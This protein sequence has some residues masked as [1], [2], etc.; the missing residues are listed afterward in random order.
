MI[1]L[2]GKKI[3]MTQ[4]FDDEGKQVPLTLIE[5]S[6][7]YVTGLRTA[8][9]HGYS[10]VQLGFDSKVK[11]KNLNK[12]VVGSF[13]KNG[14]PLLRFLREIRT[15]TLEGLEVAMKLGVEQFQEGEFVD[16][17]GVSIGKGF[18]GV[19]KRHHFKGGTGGRGTK[20]GREPGGIGSRAGGN[21]CRKKVAKGKALPGHMGQ[22][23]V[24]VQ[25][26]KVVKV[27]SEHGVIA[28]RGAVPGADGSYLEIRSALK[29]RTG[30]RKWRVPAKDVVQ[31]TRESSPVVSL[32]NESDSIGKKQ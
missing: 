12:S 6:P 17:G 5:A 15:E 21:G 9:K 2:L 23:I 22:D 3:G 1:G 30:E 27:D 16:V 7:C 29:I 8:A 26:L 20:M 32:P 18:Q 4:V 25:N 31:P 14:L 13:K 11:E 28:V 19:V 24:T 10:A